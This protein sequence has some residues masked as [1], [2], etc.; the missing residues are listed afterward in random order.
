MKHNEK[1][2]NRMVNL[3]ILEAHEVEIEGETDVEYHMHH[4]RC[5]RRDLPAGA[6]HVSGM[7]NTYLLDKIRIDRRKTEGITAID[8]DHYITSNVMER[9]MHNLKT[10]SGQTDNRR[11]IIYA[12]LG[13]LAI[14]LA[15]PLFS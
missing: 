2:L 14:I 1:R 10:S 9:A 13:I 12:G 7:S 4:L 15:Y 8:L 11:T 3:K 5:K 6:V